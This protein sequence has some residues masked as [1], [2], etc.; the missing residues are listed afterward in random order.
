VTKKITRRKFITATG[1]EPE[2]DDLERCNCPNAG[3][4]GHFCC[5]WDYKYD[6]P[7]FETYGRTPPLRS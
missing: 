6:L 7:I 2:Q 4:I 5:G 1:R 3:A